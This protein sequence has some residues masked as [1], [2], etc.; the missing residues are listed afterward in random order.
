MEQ[1]APG[2][3]CAAD[4]SVNMY[5]HDDNMEILRAQKQQRA[6][7]E[8][9]SRFVFPKTNASKILPKICVCSYAKCHTLAA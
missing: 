3:E 9:L 7:P 8:R 2:S 5:A 4:I 1:I 6:F